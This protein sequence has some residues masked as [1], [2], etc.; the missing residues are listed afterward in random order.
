MTQRT[1]Y[2]AS[3]WQTLQFAPFWIFTGV[4]AIDGNIDKQEMAAFAKELADALLYKNPLVQEVLLSVVG[5]MDSIMKK[6]RADSRQVTDGLRDVADLVERKLTAAQAKEFKM[7]LLFMAKKIAEASGGGPLG[8]GE[9][10]SD[11]EKASMVLMAQALR[12]I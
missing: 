6:Y 7:T 3:E 1:N 12:A 5:D 9:N 8:L 10:V 11:S 4:A 2:T